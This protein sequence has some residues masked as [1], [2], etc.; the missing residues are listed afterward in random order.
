MNMQ[1]T[2][3]FDLD[4]APIS[5]KDVTLLVQDLDRM[6]QFYRD[7]LGLKILGST[8][9]EVLLGV[10]TPFLTLS[11]PGGLTRNPQGRPGLFHIAFLMPSRR[12]LGAWFQYAKAAGHHLVGSDHNVSEAMYL[13]DPEGNGIEVYADRPFAEWHDE[14]GR[15]R[16]G[17]KPLDTASLPTALW[18]GAPK[19]TRV[20]HVHLRTTDLTVARTFW[21]AQGF[22]IM[23]QY[24]GAVFLGA[25]GYH[26]Q[27]AT[28]TWAGEGLQPRS[29]GLTGLS[30][31]TLLAPQAKPETLVAPS[32]VRITF[33][34]E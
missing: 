29:D 21:T 4:T 30:D 8:G 7:L 20:G 22:D 32:G 9:S 15:I 11:A 28:N 23:A 1:Q 17:T 26:H 5:V 12:D 34:P 16:M 33:T 25:G 14:Q 10:E 27:L 31:I 13:S 18:K 6:A 3:V 24:P 19:G 2:N